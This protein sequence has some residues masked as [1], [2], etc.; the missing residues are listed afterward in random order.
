MQG[1]RR[2]QLKHLFGN[3]VFYIG[4]HSFTLVV[5]CENYSLQELLRIL[6]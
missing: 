5:A 4:D 3:A 1:M 6:D 2:M